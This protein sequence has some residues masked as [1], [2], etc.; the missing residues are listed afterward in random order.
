MGSILVT[1]LNN[2]DTKWKNAA[3]K[4]QNDQRLRSLTDEGLFP[5]TQKN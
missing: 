1:L 3:E 5:A 2:F 4:E